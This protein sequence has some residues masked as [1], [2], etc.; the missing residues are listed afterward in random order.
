MPV[1]LAS[2]VVDMPMKRTNNH[3]KTLLPSLRT[4]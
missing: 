2:S 4:K 1:Y 3:L